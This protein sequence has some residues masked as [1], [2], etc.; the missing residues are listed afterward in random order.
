MS[1]LNVPIKTK[2]NGLVIMVVLFVIYS[3]TITISNSLQTHKRLDDVK[4]LNDLSAKL[5]LLIHETQ[6]ERGASAGFLGS[7][8]TKF[9]DILPAQ[10]LSTDV[11][12]KEY[13]VY[14]Q[15]MQLAD[16]PN[17]LRS[18]INA[19]NQALENINSIRTRVSNLNISVKD[20]VAYYTGMNKHILIVTS[21][22]AKSSQSPKLIKALDAYTNFLKSKERA[23][24]ERAVMSA[25]F[26]NDAFKPGMFAKFIKLVAEQD[27]YADSFLAMAS[28]E[29]KQAYQK[30]MN[31]SI[32]QEVQK[33]RDI[34]ISKSNVGKFGIAGEV[35]FKTIT[36]KIILLKKL[37]DMISKE[38]AQNIGKLKE[39]ATTTTFFTLSILI[40]FSIIVIAALFSLRY[41]I[42]T[43]INTALTAIRH[44]AKNKD[45][46]QSL[47]THGDHDEIAHMSVAINEMIDSFQET[48]RYASSVSTTTAN[49]STKLDGV[50]DSLT[51]NLELLQDKATSM[52]ELV[53]DVGTQ[54][55]SVEEASIS[56]TQDLDATL[57]VLENFVSQLDNVVL[58][59]EHSSSKQYEMVEKV[60]SLTEQARSIKEVLTIIGDIADQTNLLALNAAIEAARAGEHGRGFAVVA[61]EVRKLAERTQKS[62]SEISVNVNMI[63][64]NVT[65]V[66]EQTANTADEMNSISSSAQDLSSAAQE[67]RDKLSLTSDKSSDVMRK[68]TYIA[69]KTKSLID[70]MTEFVSITS[71]NDDLSHKVESVSKHLSKDSE[72]LEKVLSQFKV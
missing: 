47:Q 42:N 28:P 36:K 29:L 41:S 4:V 22:A 69:T 16:F 30:T 1:I 71:E 59:I 34:A 2:L 40:I 61:D 67:T 8:G 66:S 68:T 53:A 43:S 12:V 64:Q 19:V 58:A 13:K 60:N 72:E 15:T 25:T 62:L 38:S 32:V 24:I 6:K 52:N 20:E 49:Q 70:N 17:E 65:D 27:S 9:I 18:E 21:I 14:L 50:V 44:I 5:S 11:R 35:W 3:M 26:A 57:D 63:T 23:G 54:L 33:M 31:N 55:D 46:S 39:E 51:G 45:L 10:R 7:K 37:D 48:I 56:T